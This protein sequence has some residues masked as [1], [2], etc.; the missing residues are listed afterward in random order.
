VW[1]T[2]SGYWGSIVLH[3]PDHDLTVVWF[4]NQARLRTAEMQPTLIRVLALAGV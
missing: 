2:H 3:D 1:W 4:R